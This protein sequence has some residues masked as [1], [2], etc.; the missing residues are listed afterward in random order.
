MRLIKQALLWGI[1]VFFATGTGQ[2]QE[3]DSPAPG[4][5][6]G[7]ATAVSLARSGQ[8]PAALALLAKLAGQPCPLPEVL[9]DYAAVAVWAGEYSR[10]VQVYETG[11]LPLE[12]DVPV[13]VT[14]SVAEAY[15][16]L[17]RFRTAQ[18]MYQQ[19]AAAG[20][21][22]AR[23]WEA[24][25]LTELGDTG[26]ALRIFDE[27]LAGGKGDSQLYISRALAYIRGHDTVSAMQDTRIALSLAAD[28]GETAGTAEIRAVIAA[29]LIRSG[30]YSP[31]IVLL[32]PA[33]DARTATLLMECDYLLALT[34]NGDYAGA[35]DAGKA[36]WPQPGLVP[37][38]GRRALADAYLRAGRPAAAMKLYQSMAGDPEFSAA[39]HQSLAFSCLLAG[40]HGPAL[41]RYE[42]LLDL[43]TERA[44]LLAYDGEALLTRGQYAAGRQLFQLILDRYPEE[45]LLRQRYAGR[46]AAKG[47]YRE[48]WEQYE[49]LQRQPGF[50]LTGA[51]GMAAMATQAGDYRAARRAVAFLAA[52][53]P[54]GAA[55][56]HA[57][58]LF[59]DRP[60]GELEMGFSHTSDYKGNDVLLRQLAG[61]QRLGDRLVFLG[62]QEERRIKDS[63]DWIRLKAFRSGLRYADLRQAV[64]AWGEWPGHSGAGTGYGLAYRHYFGE[65]SSL[66]FSREKLPVYDVQALTAGIMQTAS[67]LVWGRQ[68]GDNDFYTLGLSAAAYSDGNASLSY[69]AFWA[70][71]L[72]SDSRREFSWFVYAAGTAFDHQQINGEATGYESPELRESYGG[73][74]KHRWLRPPGYWEGT[75]AIEWGRDRPEPTDLSPYARLEYGWQT[76]A[77]GV[78]TAGLAY[79][80]RTGRSAKAGSGL[81]FGYR[82]YDVRYHLQW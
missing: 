39:D 63:A 3:L 38:Y 21:A 10:A 50:R 65:R 4:E 60:L 45:S 42:E 22:Q 26:Q 8:Y 13:Y 82:Q 6:G 24:E 2:G 44:G 62:G 12:P 29:A 66:T 69:D 27:L 67:R 11:I 18:A 20:H 17:G 73:G 54:P 79:G 47:L 78:L 55:A 19:L 35:I 23:L 5:L 74:I 52:E 51:A 57:A 77:A 7:H 34:S 43:G 33:I 71:Y 15:F 81:H 25:C 68:V 58:A 31:A 70:H 1:L 61:E 9:F 49:A 59:D 64:E 28:G 56:A 48:A 37:V 14:V 75:L 32:K 53:S 80:A 36:L 30:D 46:L 40:K 76:S 72:H 16:R 41:R